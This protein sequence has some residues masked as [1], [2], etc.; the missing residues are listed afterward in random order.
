M[1]HCYSFSIIE[2]QVHPS[3]CAF[4]L[5]ELVSLAWL[6]GPSYV[7]PTGDTG[8]LEIGSV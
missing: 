5:L 3:L 2:L 4:A 8:L 6:A 1:S 7:L